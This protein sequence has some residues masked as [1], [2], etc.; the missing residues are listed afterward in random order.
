[1]GVQ[2]GGGVIGKRV[3]PNVFAASSVW[4]LSE[5]EAATRGAIWPSLSPVTSG[6]QL[7][8]D[9]SDR[10][11]MY[12]AT[13]GG[14]TV[15]VNGTVARWEDK[16]GNARHFTQS[17]SDLRPTLRVV[18][19][20]GL[21]AVGFANNWMSGTYTYTVGSVFVVWNQP[22]TTSGDLYPSI[23]S[24]RTANSVKVANSSLNYNISVIAAGSPNAIALDPSPSSATHRLDG[25]PAGSNFI[26]Y[27][28]GVGVLT[29]PD[30]WQHTNSTFSAVSGTK[31]FVVGADTFPASG[32]AM[33]NG[34]IGEILIYSG[35][36]TSTQVL[37]VEAYLVAKWGL[38]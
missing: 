12:D 2:R 27:T 30:R 11:T 7:W 4:S 37:A 29:S 16:S 15:E 17:T 34:H 26:A 3:L 6:L 18:V 20:N 31:P 13:S 23:L 10:M 28:V 35:T 33:Q 36:L 22:T 5:A 21:G 14:S 19:K 25:Y 1:M 32:R 24:A 9:G 8:L 38:A